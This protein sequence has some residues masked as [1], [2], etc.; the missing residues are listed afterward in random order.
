[1]T[2][3]EFVYDPDSCMVKT[4]L[5]ETTELQEEVS[6]K[7]F[8]PTSEKPIYMIICFHEPPERDD[9][10]LLYTTC[11]GHGLFSVDDV[12]KEVIESFEKPADEWNIVCY[13]VNEA[14]SAAAELTSSQTAEKWTVKITDDP[15]HGIK[16]WR[17]KTQESSAAET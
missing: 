8:A 3:I 12:E 6:R 15:P 10:E 2:L 11:I 7:Y 13:N 9:L 5:H 16:Q 17:R 4:E 1:M 14:F